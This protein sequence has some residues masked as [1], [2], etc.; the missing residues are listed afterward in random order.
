MDG[1]GWKVEGWKGEG[2][3]GDSCSPWLHQPGFLLKVPAEPK[4]WLKQR[5][6][7]RHP[8]LV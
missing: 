4:H 1:E 7:G 6:A 2:W 5:P 3:G 8:G